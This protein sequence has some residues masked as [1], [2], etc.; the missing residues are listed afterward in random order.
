MSNYEIIVVGAGPAG[1][2]SALQLLNLNPE[3]AGQILL[4]DKALFPRA[5]LCAGGLSPAADRALSQLGL[6]G[7]PPDVP[8]HKA[9]LALPTGRLIFEQLNL[10][11]VVSRNSSTTFC[12]SRRGSAVPLCRTEKPSSTC[13]LHVTR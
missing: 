5:K 1:S 8:V 11:R 12:F 6:V 4:L 9:I 7:G 10:S 2:S 13:C 3:L